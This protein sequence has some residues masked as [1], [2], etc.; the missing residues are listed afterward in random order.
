MGNL[1][2]GVPREQIERLRTFRADHPGHQ[3]TI[4]G[5]CIGGVRAT[6]DEFFTSYTILSP[7]PSDC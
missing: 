7:S 3:H 4:A 6:S 1:Y 2:T 5:V